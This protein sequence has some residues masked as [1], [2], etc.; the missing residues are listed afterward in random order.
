[1]VFLWLLGELR[2]PLRSRR[3]LRLPGGEDGPARAH[4]TLGCRHAT[5]TGGGQQYVGPPGG[6]KNHGDFYLVG[7]LEHFS[8]W[9]MVFNSG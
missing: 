5:G 1:M 3:C 9:I 4:R 2:E 7:G 8:Q 6:N